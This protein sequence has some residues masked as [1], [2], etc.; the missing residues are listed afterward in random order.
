MVDLDYG[1]VS[2]WG[3]LRTTSALLDKF[4]DLTGNIDGRAI[5]YTDGQTVEIND[6]GEFT[7]GIAVPKW[8]NTNMEGEEGS[9]NTHADTDYGIF[10]LGDAYLMYAEAVLR[11][12]EGGDI[13]TAIGYIN[14]LRNRAYGNT[15]GNISQGDLDL[16]FILDERARELY[17]E[18]TR[19]IDL[20]RFGQFT[21][22]AYLWPWKGN[23]KE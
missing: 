8:T 10:R 17:F 15:D 12:G 22:D 23:V 9:D 20:V 11:N 7:E 14:E 3:G 4:P 21:G 5:F 19:R 13:G 1:V 2:G 18:G 6:V 16:P